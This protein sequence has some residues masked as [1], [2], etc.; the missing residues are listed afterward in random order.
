MAYVGHTG[1]LTCG[2][3]LWLRRSEGHS[4]QS[5]FHTG[6]LA[7]WLVVMVWTIAETQ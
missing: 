1:M 7:C 3:G 5:E 2:Y 6:M 4:S